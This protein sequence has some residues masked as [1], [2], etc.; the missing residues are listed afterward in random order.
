M[1]CRVV[2]LERWI[3][4]RRS[5][6]KA[7]F[8]V[9]YANTMQKLKYEIGRLDADEFVIEAGFTREMLR[10]DG[11]PRLAARP[12][13]HAV[14]ISFESRFGPL[15]YPCDNFRWWEDNVRAIAMTLE[16]LR[17][18][19][20]YGVAA[21]GEQYKGWAQLPPPSSRSTTSFHTIEDAVKFICEG[22]GENK[23]WWHGSILG[24]KS[25]EDLRRAYRD[26]AT[27]HHPDKGGS[28]EMMT[29]LNEAKQMVENWINS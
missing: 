13:D 25:S 4:E 6:K 17:L 26:A 5:P 29:R 11:M 1:R 8:R 2:P 20:L 24:S 21:R 18:A 28:I 19:E 7:P 12:D 14:I 22:A 27:R 9:G 15:A 23:N 10:I 16:R 3:G